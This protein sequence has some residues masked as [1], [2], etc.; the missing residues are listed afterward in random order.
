[1]EERFFEQ[2][3]NEIGEENALKNEEM[4]PHTTMKVGGPADYYFTPECKK[5]FGFVIKTLKEAGENF[6]VLGNASNVIVK[7]AGFRG[8]IIQTQ[9]MNKITVDGDVITARAGA[10]LKQIA[11][12]AWEAGL[13]GFEFASGI[14]GSIGGAV[15]GNAGAYDSEMSDVV[16][17]VAVYDE[18]GELTETSE[19]GF[20]Y[21]TSSFADGTKYIAE[22]KIKLFP[23]D[24]AEIRARMDDLESQRAAKQP[25]DLPSCGS[26]F[27]R[28]EGYYAGKLIEDAG[29]AGQRVGGVSV[30]RKHCGFIVNDRQGTATDVLGLTKLIQRNV[31]E[32]FGVELECEIKVL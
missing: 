19:C 28:P 25:L 23:K 11:E 30:S 21:R 24:K 7:D 18:N 8:A 16:E 22:V 1:M 31:K 5:Q 6:R 2:I 12:A 10:G 15:A 17:S 29:M 14:P 20:G 4:A 9:K 3:R 26:V 27:K 13:G 32:K